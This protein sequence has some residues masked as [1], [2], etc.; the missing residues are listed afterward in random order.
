MSNDPVVTIPSCL[1]PDP[2]PAPPAPVRTVDEALATALREANA[3]CR[4]L[5][6]EPSRRDHFSPLSDF[7][8]VPEDDAYVIKASKRQQQA[9]THWTMMA[10]TPSSQPCTVA[11]IGH[12]ERIDALAV[13][14][15]YLALRRGTSLSYQI[16]VLKETLTADANGVLSLS[17]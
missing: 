13:L 5:Y 3:F 12:T 8:F 7:D 4:R 17:G 16:P 15:S 10:I 2:R 9:A 1:E 6:T 14:L 11:V